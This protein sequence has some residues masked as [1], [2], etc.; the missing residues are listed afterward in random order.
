MGHRYMVVRVVA[1]AVAPPPQMR[2]LPEGLVVRPLERLQVEAGLVE[3]RVL[4]QVAQGPLRV[5]L[6]DQ[7]VGAVAAMLPVLVE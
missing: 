2:H 3:Q 5:N 4:V 7:V 6:E 1:A